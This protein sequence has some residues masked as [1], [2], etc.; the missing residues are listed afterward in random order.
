MVEAVHQQTEGNPLFVTEIVRLLVQEGTVGAGLKP[1][2]TQDTSDSWSVRIPEGVRE[3]IGRR[4]DRLS[5]RCN[6]TLT[7]ASVVGREFTLEQLSPLIEDISADRLLEV[8]EE[9]LASRVIEELPRSV[10]RYQ[11]THA[12]VQETLA[13]ELSTTR[14]VRLHAR[15]A[16]SLEELY[17]D[18]AE[19][20]ASELAQHFF[21]GQTVLGTDKLIRYSLLAGERA[22]SAYAYEE[23]LVHFQRGL[24]AT[25]VPLTGSE[26]APGGQAAALLFGLARAQTATL[27]RNQIQD[28]VTTMSRAFDYYAE[29]GELE[30]AVAV[31]EYPMGTFAGHPTG[32]TRLLERA[33]ALVQVDSHQ[34]GRL[35]SQYGRVLCLERGNYEGA[36]RA[37]GRAQAI[38]QRE[39]DEGLEMRT[40]ISS[41]SVELNNMH[42]V[43]CLEKSLRAIELAQRLGD[44]YAEVDARW[45]AFSC[46]LVRGEV[47]AEKHIAAMLAVA[48][49]LRGPA[50]ASHRILW[51]RIGRMFKGR[52]ARC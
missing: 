50:L 35:L 21:E 40:L 37:F 13:G 2:P 36:G 16:G 19:A 27:E 4:L 46:L 20:H 17:S 8:L 32:I 41:S 45:S 34:A 23:A 42:F 12:L 28:A 10:G 31:A 7:I 18:E 25:G 11:F 3:V 22:L 33:V 14:K 26:Q 52:L 51:Q 1:A 38:A 15:I 24:T 47:E 6:E 43:D 29:T 39:G 30:R 5:E 48:E 9:A 49:Q 44:V